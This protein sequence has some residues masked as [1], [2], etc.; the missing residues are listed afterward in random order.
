MIERWLLAILLLLPAPALAVPAYV[1]MADGGAVVRVITTGS[2]PAATVDGQ[3]L[4]LALRSAAGMVAQRQTSSPPELSKPSAFPVNVCEAAL[5]AGARR[6]SIDGR[7][8]P[9]PKINVARIVVI[10]DT[11]C[12]L[13][14]ADSAY[15][16]CNS[17]DAFAF[18]RVAVQAARWRPDL[19]VHVGDY[20]YRENPCPAGN[21]GCAGSPWGY[22]WDAWSAD[23]F[24]PAAPLLA[25]APLALARGNHE[26]CNR[27]GQGWW[28]FLAAQPLVAG[29]DCN[30]PANDHAGD[31]SPPYAVALGSSAQLVMLDMAAVGTKALDSGDWRVP[32][33]QAQWRRLAELAGAATSTITVEHYPMLGLA[34]VHSGAGVTL[35]PGNLAIQSVFGTHGP[36][37]LPPGVDVMLAGHVH[38]WEQIGFASDH[39]SQFIIGF[40]GTQEDVVPIP[41]VLPPG[42]SPLPAA[43]I[44]NFSSWTNGF[45]FMTMQRS[46]TRRWKIEVRNLRGK[47]VNRCQVDGQRSECD[48]PQVVSS[49]VR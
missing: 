43:A 45:G 22:G 30:D 20:H 21:T 23:F 42:A 26:S 15:Q 11:G 34:A 14:A 37:L 5:P 49:A 10:G 19:I 32:M 9:L 36:R 2:C 33:L 35:Q 3:Q 1:V 4:P 13:K 31:T 40:S 7:H 27:A 29:Q 46:G 17:S 48:L 44:A 18:A 12:R 47:V 8:L 41:A 38:L 24:T 28:R 39:P 6:A 25:V 16:A